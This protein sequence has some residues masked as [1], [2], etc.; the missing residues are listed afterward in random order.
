MMATHLL[1]LLLQLLLFVALAG[2]HV[3]AFNVDV[4]N[5][6]RHDGPSPD[7]M[8]GFSVALHR[9]KQTSW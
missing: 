6:V 2:L 1:S 8:Y 9:E 5:Y 3:D 4:V 7:S